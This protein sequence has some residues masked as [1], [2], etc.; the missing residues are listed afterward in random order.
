MTMFIVS[1]RALPK[2]SQGELE[3]PV[4][5]LLVTD[6]RDDYCT[7]EG[8]GLWIE[9]FLE[10]LEHRV[11]ER[12]HVPRFQ[13]SETESLHERLF[14]EI[15]SSHVRALLVEFTNQHY[16]PWRDCDVE[17]PDYDDLRLDC[18]SYCDECDSGWHETYGEYDGPFPEDV[19]PDES[20]NAPGISAEERQARRRRNRTRREERERREAAREEAVSEVIDRELICDDDCDGFL[21][22]ISE[23]YHDAFNPN[24]A[25]LQR[26]WEQFLADRGELEFPSLHP[27]PARR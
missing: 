21:D 6:N 25:A 26:R 7:S 17:Y 8:D 5:K 2:A 10:F 27:L 9:P 1:P 24:T 20:E 3:V 14:A 23:A 16:A 22:C 13:F 19:E 18:R 12:A 15:K 4:P 11:R